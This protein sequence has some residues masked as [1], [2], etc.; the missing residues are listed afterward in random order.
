MLDELPSAPG[1]Y[2]LRIAL[3]RAVILPR[4]RWRGRQVDEG[5]YLYAGSAWGPGGL[6]ARLRRHLKAAK[7]LRWHVD[8]LTNIAGVSAILA[9]P[10]GRE[11][12]FTAAL[13]D[14]GATAPLPGF[15]ASDCRRCPA[16]LLKLAM[17][18]DLAA[19]A[20]PG[21]VIW[22]CPPASCRVPDP[23]GRR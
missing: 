23:P 14:K 19:L 21:D 6:R 17:D 15:G 2:V 16:H 11:C 3:E 8:A 9:R 4:G 12:A 1:A 13:L 22:R 10:G 20:R 7:T 18:W 5:V